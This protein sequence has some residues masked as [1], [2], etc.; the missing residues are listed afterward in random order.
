ML[1]G[2]ADWPEHGPD[3]DPAGEK[4]NH[5]PPP[6][7]RSRKAS[8]HVIKGTFGLVTGRI[9]QARNFVGLLSQHFSRRFPLPDQLKNSLEMHFFSLKDSIFLG[10]GLELLSPL[11]GFSHFR[12]YQTWIV[13]ESFTFSTL[14]GIQ[15]IIKHYLAH[16]MF[17]LTQSQSHWVSSQMGPTKFNQVE[18]PSY[19]SAS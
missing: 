17:G 16:P 2:W 11:V 13:E 15:L 5:T 6:G 9:S 3:L 4:K 10:E 14:K 18:V 19:S 12:C 8:M 7:N 1:S